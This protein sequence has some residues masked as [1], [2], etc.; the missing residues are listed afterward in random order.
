M[1]KVFFTLLSSTILRTS[2]FSPCYLL[3]AQSP[4]CQ[5]AGSRYLEQRLL[6]DTILRSGI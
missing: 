5:S 3:S 4:Y 2:C 6:G 1:C